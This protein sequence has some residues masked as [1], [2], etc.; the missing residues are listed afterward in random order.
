MISCAH[1]L[2]AATN[3]CRACIRPS[4]T[5]IPV[6]IGEG[7]M[8]AQLRNYWHLM[9][10]REGMAVF[11][12][13]V[14]QQALHSTGHGPHQCTYRLHNWTQCFVG[15]VFFLFVLFSKIEHMRLR[16]KSDGG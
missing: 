6:W 14:T 16:G 5:K 3:V 4:E 8:K 9:I 1:N 15:G 13:N 10:D 7:C 12:R 11:F 2:S